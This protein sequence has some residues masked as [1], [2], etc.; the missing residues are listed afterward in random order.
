MKKSINQ[1]ISFNLVILF[2][3]V[4]FTACTEKDNE[5]VV[6]DVD[7]VLTMMNGTQTAIQAPGWMMGIKTPEK[8][9]MLAGGNAILETEEEMVVTDLIRIG[10][11]TKTFV[12]S[13]TLILYDEGILSLNEKLE[14]Y[15]PDFPN[16][17]NV[18]IRQ[19]LKHTS[20]IVSWDEDEEIRMQ[21]FNGTSDWTID[22]L[23]DWAAEQPYY[24]EPGTGF[25][26][27]NIGYFL[28]GKI[29]EQSTNK[30]IA[31]LLEEKIIQPL[32]LNNTF[33]PVI[34]HPPGETIHGYDGSSGSV[35]D[36]TGT[37]QA[38][39]INF[40]LAWTSGGMLSSVED[41]LVWSKALAT[42][43]LLS[44]S[45][46]QQQLPILQPP[47]QHVPY[48]SGYGMG[49]S[50]VDVWIG[51]AGAICGYVCNMNYYV[52]KDVSIVTFYNKFS[53]FDIDENTADITAVS[54]NF[55]ELARY[56]C[57][58]TLQPQ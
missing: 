53:A 29:I 43:E 28:L 11:I 48:S 32:S 45:L 26:Y 12:A 23:I 24:F 46:H 38:D 39:A 34:P 49:I 57:P 1:G 18:T 54:N 15:Y 4:I 8:G 3:S 47:S 7:V 35:V 19:L 52:E 40:E 20:G 51:H 13:L 56:F 31:E 6:T 55:M 22:K 16:A 14:D 25:H 5:P 27:S 50:Q 2:L 37:P 58:E 41:L 44:D 10:S 30:T 17:D 42:G 21:I 9:F 36:M 33:L